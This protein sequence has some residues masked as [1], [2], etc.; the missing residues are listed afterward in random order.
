MGD[1]A[2]GLVPRPDVGEDR[3]LE[4][5]EAIVAA[6]VVPVDDRGE[7]EVVAGDHEAPPLGERDPQEAVG[8]REPGVEVG[9]FVGPGNRLGERIAIADA[10]DHVFGFCLVNDWSARDIQKWEHVPLGPFLGKNFATSISP[11]VVTLDADGQHTAGHLAALLERFGSGDFDMVV[12]ARDGEDH[13]SLFRRLGNHVFNRL[14][15]WM[16]GQ[17]ILDLTSGIRVTRADRFREFLHLLPNGFSYPTTSTMAFFRSGYTVAYEPIDVQQREGRSH[18]KIW[19]EGAR[20]LVIIFKIGALYSPM[21][22]FLPVSL[23]LFAIATTLYAYTY[24][25]EG[26]FTNMSALLYMTSLL[27]FMIGIAITADAVSLSA[28]VPPF[29]VILLVVIFGREPLLLFAALGA[30]FWLDIARIVRG[31]FLQFRE[32]EFVLAARAAGASISAN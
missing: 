31:S 10:E 22:L 21:K 8:L 20:F 26:R 23:V 1:G 29:L 19:R 7:L 5:R 15:S 13:A 25:S 14:A 24:L 16:T 27:T 6:R 12:G 9:F 18:L 11:W 17:K 3:V 4:P 30:V 28:G 2:R 32:Q